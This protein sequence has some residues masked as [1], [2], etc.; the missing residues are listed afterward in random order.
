MNGFELRH[1]EES[2]P[3]GV[4]KLEPQ[5]SSSVWSFDKDI[6]MAVL[7]LENGSKVKELVFDG[8][9]VGWRLSI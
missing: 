7:D 4:N 6:S 8:G 5:H 3:D 1:S 2:H 9:G